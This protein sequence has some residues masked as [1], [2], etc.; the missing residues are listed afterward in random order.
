MTDSL[1]LLERFRD[2]RNKNPVLD[3]EIQR[4]ASR[5]A[6]AAALV[7]LRRAAGL[8]RDEIA[9]AV[10]KGNADM[11]RVESTAGELDPELLARYIDACRARLWAVDEPP[12]MP[13]DPE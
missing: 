8:T 5:R 6:L 10:G 9:E 13:T 3:G 7:G 4:T 2:L 11:S 1:D 12:P